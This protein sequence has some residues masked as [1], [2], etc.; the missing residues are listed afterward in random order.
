MSDLSKID[1]L[2]YLLEMFFLIALVLFIFVFYGSIIY[3]RNKESQFS[4]NCP[5]CG[6]MT[7]RIQRKMTDKIVSWFAFGLIKVQ[8]FRCSNCLWQSSKWM[9]KELSDAVKD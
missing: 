7:K 1:D 4:Q 9:K 5:T 6:K 3:I 2:I 8:R